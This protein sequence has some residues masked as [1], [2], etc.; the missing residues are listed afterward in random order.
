M[1]HKYLFAQTDDSGGRYDQQPCLLGR[2]L[3][4]TNRYHKQY[5]SEMSPVQHSTVQLVQ[6]HEEDTRAPMTMIHEKC[7]TNRQ[8]VDHR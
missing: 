6:R 4:L 7:K 3:I 8:V 5:E 1:S 2:K